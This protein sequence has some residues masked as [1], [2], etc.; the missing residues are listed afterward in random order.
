MLTPDAAGTGPW[1]AI[2]LY[3]DGVG[4]RPEMVEMGQRLSNAGYVV[5]VPDLFYRSGPYGPLVPA[6]VIKAGFRET[7]GPM[8]ALTGNAKSAQDTAA[9]LAWLGTNSDVKGPLV[10]TVGFCMGGGMAI[11]AA[12]VY[13]DR[14]AAAAS[15]H[16]GSLA[17]D[18]PQSPHL[19]AP[20]IKGE[21]LVA[22]AD[23][24][25][26]Y[27]PEMAERL[28]AALTEAGVKFH[29]EIYKGAHHGWMKKDFP[30]YDEAAAERGWSEML[31][32]FARNLH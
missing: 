28:V 23:E 30:V 7:V 10:G 31:A 8:M 1:P 15:F 2:I 3:M 27:P 13:P 11:T 32:L 18:D 20:Q 17:T 9:F 14:V 16:G 21:L 12:G 6:E 26:S 4:M 22:G 29:A 5:L 19:L 24:D 25:G